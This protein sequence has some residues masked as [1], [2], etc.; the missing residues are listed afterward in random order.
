MSIKSTPSRY[1]QPSSSQ[2]PTQ[3]RA[4][5]YSD[6]YDDDDDTD[7]VVLK[8]TTKPA[9]VRPTEK[10]TYS[11]KPNTAT[12]AKKTQ[13]PIGNRDI[14]SLASYIIKRLFLLWMAINTLLIVADGAIGVFYTGP[15]LIYTSCYADTNA[16]WLDCAN[17]TSSLIFSMTGKHIVDPI[18][19]VGNLVKFVKQSS[20]S[21][22]VHHHTAT[23]G[24]NAGGNAATQPSAHVIYG[25]NHSPMNIAL[26]HF[27]NKSVISIIN[28]SLSNAANMKKIY[29]S[30]C[31]SNVPNPSS[32]VKSSSVGYQAYPWII[33]AAS[34]DDLSFNFANDVGAMIGEVAAQKNLNVE[35]SNGHRMQMVVIAHV[36]D[37]CQHVTSSGL[38]LKFAARSTSADTCLAATPIID[39]LIIVMSADNDDPL[40]TPVGLIEAAI[41]QNSALSIWL[42]TYEQ[43]FSNIGGRNDRIIVPTNQPTLAW[44]SFYMSDAN[45]TL[46]ESKQ[47]AR[48]NWRH[49]SNTLPMS[50][51]PIAFQMP[52]THLHASI[53]MQLT[54]CYDIFVNQYTGVRK[55][56]VMP[57]DC[58]IDRE[59]SAILISNNALYT[60]AIES[61]NDGVTIIRSSS[62]TRNQFNMNLGIFEMTI[63][64]PSSVQN[65]PIQ[66]GHVQQDW[67]DYFSIMAWRHLDIYLGVEYRSNEDG[68][69]SNSIS[70]PSIEGL[71]GA[72]ESTKAVLRVDMQQWL[73][74]RMISLNTTRS[75]VIVFANSHI[76]QSVMLSKFHR[77][78]SPS[79]TDWDL[80]ALF[81][82]AEAIRTI[83]RHCSYDTSVDRMN[84]VAFLNTA[85][86]HD[87][88]AQFFEL[89]KTDT[90]DESGA[91][92]DSKHR[93]P[94][95]HENTETSTAFTTGECMVFA[96]SMA[97]YRVL[98]AYPFAKRNMVVDSV[99]HR[100]ALNNVHE[101]MASPK[102]L[103]KTPSPIIAC[104]HDPVSAWRPHQWRSLH[105][106]S[107]HVQTWGRIM[108]R[109]T[110]IVSKDGVLRR[111]LHHVFIGDA[112]A[113]YDGNTHLERMPV[114]N[115]WMTQV[116]HLMKQ[117]YGVDDARKMSKE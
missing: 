17:H 45:V 14:R 21:S 30:P 96:E 75:R 47:W 105:I 33:A 102:M 9:S 42:N 20:H 93:S 1:T 108:D 94:L 52:N 27:G 110:S 117:C 53:M 36:N 5:R 41:W 7:T 38:K 35:Y 64:M 29:A 100:Q 101:E 65:A 28:P 79:A 92:S 19:R 103:L 37:A 50:T 107:D 56:V 22:N 78:V 115:A 106:T 88:I 34:M 80:H 76:P 48:L 2:Q 72:D 31:T 58:I 104:N 61:N 26:H 85:E 87:S 32:P 113:Q 66:Y 13:Q 67:Y 116:Q 55:H 43:L 46:A 24:S 4:L 63:T 40:L 23:V 86:L 16:S 8:S 57:S 25:S 12:A 10:A 89:Q 18:F 70:L 97:W 39:A 51:S 6:L 68:D 111:A 77:I 91:N 71:L 99:L 73:Q 98:H 74:R 11:E 109:Q 3:R 112:H 60:Y 84:S 81:D 59:K 49:M 62:S 114:I 82:D 44:H 54:S 90:V 83:H 15:Y 95:M 69:S